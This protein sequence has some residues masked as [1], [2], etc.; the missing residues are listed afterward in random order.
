MHIL[1]RWALR[2]CE[3]SLK[4]ASFFF[5]FFF[6]C[7]YADTFFSKTTTSEKCGSGSGVKDLSTLPTF[8]FP[9]YSPYLNIKRN[10]RLNQGLSRLKRTAMKMWPFLHLNKGLPCPLL[11][12]PK[13]FRVNEGSAGPEKAPSGFSNLMYSRW[14]RYL[15]DIYQTPGKCQG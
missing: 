4:K 3:L 1:T 12:A 14:V 7:H 9:H 2:F 13:I 15:G 10:K 8:C 6:K 11:T 5:F